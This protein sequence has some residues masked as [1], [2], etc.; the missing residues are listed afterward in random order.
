VKKN[1]L[2]IVFIIELSIFSFGV[3]LASVAKANPSIPP[4]IPP[5]VGVHEMN[6]NTTI[7]KVNGVLWAKVD[8]EYRTNTIHGFGDSYVLTKEFSSVTD[9]SPFI[10]ITV[11]SNRLEAHYPI[12][13]N[14]TNITVKIND[15]EKDWQIDNKRF[16]HLFDTT[17]PEIN[18]TISPVPRN[19]IVT[20]HYEHPISKTS[21]LYE[22]LGDHALLLPLGPRYGSTDTPSYPLYSWFGYGTITAKFTIQ[23]EPSIT[24]IQVYS[25][26]GRGTL[27]PLNYT[28]STKNGTENIQTVISKG[29]EET[30]FPHGAVVVF[31]A[32]PETPEEPP[33]TTTAAVTITLVSVIVI[34]TVLI[35]YHKKR[36]Q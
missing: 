7:S 8:A 5:I 28:N 27:T 11:I 34:A 17:H 26:D 35:V 6:V 32:N 31:N 10:T 9:P 3:Q 24:Q 23:T 29:T 30:P 18:W 36:D 16:Y 19:F 4:E 33:Q 15:E 25:I 12:P 20:T 22:Y 14:A 1:A 13:A 2:T 21:E